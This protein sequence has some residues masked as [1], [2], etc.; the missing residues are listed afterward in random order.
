[1]NPTA[2]CRAA[3]SQRRTVD[4]VVVQVRLP[5]ELVKRIDHLCVDRDWTRSAFFERV[6]RE[7]LPRLEQGDEPGPLEWPSEFQPKDLAEEALQS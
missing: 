4:R 7:G 6:I 2:S 3:V 5:R 1:M